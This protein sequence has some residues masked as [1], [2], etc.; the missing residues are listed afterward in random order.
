MSLL[1]SARHPDLRAFVQR[2]F[3]EID[4]AEEWLQ[5][6]DVD[7][8]PAL[9]AIIDMDLAFAEYRLHATKCALRFHG[10]D[11]PAIG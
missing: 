8:R 3:A 10:R 4:E 1:E 11:A 7:T 9:L 5:H 2:A 6:A